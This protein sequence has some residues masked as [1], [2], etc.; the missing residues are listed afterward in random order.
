MRK[1][2]APAS[3]P[4]RAAAEAV[5]LDAI[6]I[7]DYGSAVASAFAFR[8]AQAVRLGYETSDASA[9]VEWY[10]EQLREIFA[11]HPAILRLTPQPT[12]TAMQRAAAMMHVFGV[13]KPPRR[14]IFPELHTGANFSADVGARMILGAAHHRRHIREFREFSPNAKVRVGVC[15]D[16]RACKACRSL[17]RHRFTLDAAPELPHAECTSPD[18]CRCCLELDLK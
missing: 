17:K 6:D 15:S 11:L 7:G 13:S 5:C 4:V 10:T 2:P 18:G 14:W 9:S 3:D 1:P 8:T 16:A 12:L